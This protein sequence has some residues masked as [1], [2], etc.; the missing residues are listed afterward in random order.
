VGFPKQEVW[1]MKLVYDTE[2]VEALYHLKSKQFFDLASYLK[3][4]KFALERQTKELVD[5]CPFPPTDV[6]DEILFNG[7][8]LDEDGPSIEL[9]SP[10]PF[11]PTDKDDEIFSH[12]IDL[13]EVVKIDK[14]DFDFDELSMISLNVNFEYIRQGKMILEK[15]NFNEYRSFDILSDFCL[16]I[17]NLYGGHVFRQ[18]ILP[19]IG[20]IKQIDAMAYLI[21]GKAYELIG[22]W[23]AKS[24]KK[25]IGK[26]GGRGQ[27]KKME[28]RINDVEKKV[29]RFAREKNGKYEIK[30][31]DWYRILQ[32]TF[33][34]HNIPVSYPTM[35]KYKK[36]IETRISNEKGHRFK[37][38][39]KK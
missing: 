16:I 22:Y 37:I 20:M 7:T 9:V 1:E 39:I 32:E 6:D 38:N 33:G 19:Y 18:N 8:N 2:E 31:S 14:E 27:I 29:K 34:Y 11:P 10:F 23:K 15:I 13:N 24:N 30:R 3:A 17:N 5:Q 36:E 26:P 12:K 35:I 28:E 21:A 4:C 25:E